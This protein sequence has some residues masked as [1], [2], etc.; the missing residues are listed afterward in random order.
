MRWRRPWRVARH[1]DRDALFEHV[2][3]AK[4]LAGNSDGLVQ[5]ATRIV[6][7]IKDDAC[8]ALRLD[9]GERRLQILRHRSHRNS[10]ARPL[11]KI[12]L[13]TDVP[14]KY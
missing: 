10:Q 9:L 5:A 3:A 14:N 6:P 12:N 11:N 4:E 1:V 8:R 7:Q 2:A 13:L